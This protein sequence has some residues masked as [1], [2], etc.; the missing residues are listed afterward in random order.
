MDE[1]TIYS[2][3]RISSINKDLLLEIVNELQQVINYVKENIFIKSKESNCTI[4][5]NE[6]ESRKKED[7]DFYFFNINDIYT[8]AKKKKFK[9]KLGEK[10]KESEIL[11]ISKDY[12]E[13][14]DN[15]EEK[16]N[17]INNQKFDNKY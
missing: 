7:N 17:N 8:K 3:E 4:N 16:D 10:R 9:I 12:D 15:K 11:N 6:E 2:K 14:L 1:N 13:N 5:L